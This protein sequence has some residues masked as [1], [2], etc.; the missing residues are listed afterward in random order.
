MKSTVD[1]VNKTIIKG[2]NLRRVEN[3][4]PE[5]DKKNPHRPHWQGRLLKL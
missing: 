5:P 2:G 3:E 4:N 1:V